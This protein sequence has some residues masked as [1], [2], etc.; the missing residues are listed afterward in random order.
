MAQVTTLLT[1]AVMLVLVTADLNLDQ[2]HRIAYFLPLSKFLQNILLT[3]FKIPFE[4]I[5][6]L[7]LLNSISVEI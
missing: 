2:K 6:E 3:I 5:I 7:N 4:M 1:R